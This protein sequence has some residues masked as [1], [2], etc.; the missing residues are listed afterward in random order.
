MTQEN[1]RS[2][3][4]L[5]RGADWLVYA[6]IAFATLLQALFGEYRT[7]ADTV[8]YLDISDAIRNHDWRH[9]FNGNWFPLF[10]G[11]ITLGRAL[12]GFRPQYD[13]MAGRL[14]NAGCRL[15]FAGASVLLA[16]AVRKLL[17]ARGLRSDQLLPART[18]YLLVAVVAWLFASLDFTFIKPDALVSA[19]MVL[20]L[21]AMSRAIRRNTLLDFAA[22]GLLAA[23]AFWAKAFAFPFFIGLILLTALVNLRKPRVLAGLAIA[24]VVFAAVAG[25][26][27]LQISQLRGRFTYGEAG[28]LDM[29]WYVNHADRFN[30][31]NDPRAWGPGDATA[32]FK[33][34][35]ELLTLSPQV[36]YYGG[37]ASYGSTPQ[38][39]DV[40][41][42]SDGLF[43]DFVLRDTLASVAS[44][45]L[46]VASAL[47][48]RIQPFLLAVA[49]G[50]WGFWPRK[51]SVADPFLTVAALLA[52]GSIGLYAMVYIELRYIV[53]AFVIVFVVYAGSSLAADSAPD[54]GSLHAA[55]V[56]IGLILLAQ[57]LQT[58][59]R[60]Y[61]TASAQGAQPLHGIY[62]APVFTAGA[63][64]QGL[65][66]QGGEVACLGDAACFGDTFWARFGGV[67]MTATIETGRGDRDLRDLKSAELGC[68]KIEANPAALE[69][70]RERNV[71]AIVGFFDRGQP[72]SAV[73]K[74]LGAGSGYFVLPLYSGAISAPRQ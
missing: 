51:R 62:S 60:E 36:S 66:P 25:P 28:R 65:Y 55:A 19:L 48:M 35:G 43:P 70:L 9:A 32:R 71:L 52:V 54:R 29:A 58:T 53:F 67:R 1:S 57:A 22:A 10:P 17:V 16:A 21:A 69:G 30:P 42:W 41:Y 24:V 39:T 37:P 49:L 59:L 72:C 44:N 20:T 13:L 47:P 64:L 8:A 40:S 33:H 5:P 73:W 6:G 31:V 2:S 23:L 50:M 12:F 38:W 14:G 26:Y 34:P 3:V 46:V 63:A 11:L 7:D 18:L 4:W 56:L 15:L 27:M 74:P 45:T 61:K 68:R